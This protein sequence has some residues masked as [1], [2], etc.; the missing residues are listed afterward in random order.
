M[1]VVFSF[2]ALVAV[3]LVLEAIALVIKIEN[4]GLALFIQKCI[5]AE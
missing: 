2:G 3:S 5:E 4:P 1:T